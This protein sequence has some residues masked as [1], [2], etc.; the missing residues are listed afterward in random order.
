MT[1][2]RFLPIALL[3]LLSSCLLQTTNAQ[4]IQLTVDEFYDLSTTGQLDLVID[5]RTEREWNEGHIENATFV[6]SLQNTLATTTDYQATLQELGLWG[7]RECRVAVYCQSGRR[8]GVALDHLVKAGFNGPLYNGLGVG[9]WQNA[10]YE[11]VVDEPSVE[12]P[13]MSTSAV[14]RQAAFCKAATPPLPPAE[15][16][17]DDGPF[18]FDEGITD[19][20]PYQMELDT[21]K[22]LFMAQ[23]DMHNATAYSFNFTLSCF[24][25]PADYP[26][27]VTVQL[28]H[29]MMGVKPFPSNDTESVM[30]KLT[31]NPVHMVTEDKVLSAITTTGEDVLLMEESYLQT[32]SIMDLFGRI[33]GAI[34]REA[35]DIRVV[36]NEMWGY[37][38]E[39]YIDYNF[40]MADE[41]FYT[42]V[43]DFMLVEL[44]EEMEEDDESYDME[45]NRTLIDL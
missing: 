9:Q 14:S 45:S 3:L 10:G 20:A 26:W 34:D 30:P 21:A 41:E 33:Q 24:C 23:L 27:V 8:A 15:P 43:S 29:L 11:L 32:F 16:E 44:L 42:T 4:V 2:S 1:F 12:R 19:Y 18:P 22:E 7:C 13:C 25:P 35:A 6:V 5:V 36:Y 40:M 38:E 31:V 28:E 17:T 37:P 39:I